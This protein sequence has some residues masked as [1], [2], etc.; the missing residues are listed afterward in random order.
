MYE[1]IDSFL[2]YNVQDAL[3]VLQPRPESTS[4]GV[5]RG[6]LNDMDDEDRAAAD[7]LSFGLGDSLARTIS[8][9]SAWAKS[10]ATVISDVSLPS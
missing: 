1:W 5:S 2:G 8:Q 9:D 3:E 4:D 10:L 6:P 7:A